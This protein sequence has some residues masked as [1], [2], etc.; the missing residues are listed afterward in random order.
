MRAVAEDNEPRRPG[1]PGENRSRKSRFGQA[2]GLRG[3]LFCARL[4]VLFLRTN[5]LVQA[6][7][8]NE[9][10]GKQGL[11]DLPALWVADHYPPPPKPEPEAPVTA[12]KG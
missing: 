8:T 11:P 1:G 2:V 10:L 12:A 9:W 4:R 5:S 7:L 6:A 3:G